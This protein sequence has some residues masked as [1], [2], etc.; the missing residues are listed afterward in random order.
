[1]RC[2][3]VAEASAD[4]IGYHDREW[5]TPVHD[6][7][8][9]RRAFSDFEPQAVAMKTDRDVALLMREPSII[10]NRA[11]IEATVTNARVLTSLSLNGLAWRHQP[12]RR[13]PLRDWNDGRAASPESH[14]LAN[15]LRHQG[16]RMVGPVVTHSFMQTVGVDNGHFDGCFRAP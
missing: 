7:A 14:E 10:R 12:P 1:M 3:W 9:L 13:H 5:G 6:E 16:F 2:G 11:K 8:A 4:L 15:E